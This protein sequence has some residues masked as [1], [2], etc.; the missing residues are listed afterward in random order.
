MQKSRKWLSAKNDQ[1]GGQEKVESR[2]HKNAENPHE[3][4]KTQAK[5]VKN[6]TKTHGQIPTCVALSPK[7]REPCY[8]SGAA[9]MP[10]VFPGH[11]LG[12][13]V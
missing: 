10:P 8:R 1:N 2:E 13:R 5:S 3:T 12:L 7:P 6:Q 4:T 11:G 9:L